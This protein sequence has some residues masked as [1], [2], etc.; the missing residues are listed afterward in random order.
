MLLPSPV[1]PTPSGPFPDPKK[2]VFSLPSYP[3]PIST[4][5][6]R[7]PVVLFRYTCVV[8]CYRQDTRRPLKPRHVFLTGLDTNKYLPTRGT[9]YQT[10]ATQSRLF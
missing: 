6:G 8:S 5:L 10:V 1:T 4:V 7:A 9:S 3:G 2:V